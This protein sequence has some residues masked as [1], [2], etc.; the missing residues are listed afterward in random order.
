[1]AE[2]IS[3][4]FFD[5]L[6]QNGFPPERGGPPR[7]CQVDIMMFPVELKSVFANKPVQ[8]FDCGTFFGKGADM[9]N[10]SCLSLPRS[11]EAAHHQASLN[12]FSCEVFPAHGLPPWNQQNPVAGSSESG[13]SSA[14]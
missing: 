11:S 8:D 3:E 6:A 12:L 13:S 7:I 4:N 9:E 2:Q 14:C 1:M 10:L 5:R